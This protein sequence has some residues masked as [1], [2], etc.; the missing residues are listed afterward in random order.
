MKKKIKIMYLYKIKR[1]EEKVYTTN[2]LRPD[3][4]FFI[5]NEFWNFTRIYHP[6]DYLIK[7]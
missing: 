5:K 2:D 6:K 1:N 4:K 7:V 3:K